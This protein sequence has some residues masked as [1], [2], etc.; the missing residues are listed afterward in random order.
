MCDLLRLK[1]PDLHTWTTS[2][3]WQKVEILIAGSDS[4]DYEFKAFRS[5][6]SEKYT[7]KGTFVLEDGKIVY[8]APAGSITTFFEK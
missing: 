1:R 6:A 7:G 8:E 3:T 5:S 4:Q 2:M